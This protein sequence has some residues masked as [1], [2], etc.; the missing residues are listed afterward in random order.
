[1][2][3]LGTSYRNS[4][5]ADC[6][7]A[8]VIGSGM[9]GLA[10]AALLAKHGGKRV[11]VLERNRVAG[12]FTHSFERSGY[13]WNVGVHY[14]G[15]VEDR[16]SLVAEAIDHLTEGRLRWS[17]LPEVYDRLRIGAKEYDMVAGQERFRARMTSYFPSEAANIDRYLAAVKSCFETSTA[18][19]KERA[20]PRAFAWLAGPSL[21]WPFLRWARRTTADVLGR[22]TPHRELAGVLT[23]QWGDYGLPP[24]QSSFGVHSMLVS[25]YMGG[26]SYPVGGTSSLAA[27]VAP[28]IESSGGRILVNAEVSEILLDR[29]QRAVGVRMRDGR[30]LRAG[31]VIS[32]AGARNTFTSLLPADAPGVAAAI[33]ELRSVPP[34]IAHLCLFVGIPQS[35]NNLGLAGANLWI[36]PTPDHDA[37]MAR[38]ARD[39]TAPFPLLFIS[40]PSANDPDFQRRHPGRATLEVVCL[41]PYRWFARWEQPGGALPDH[42]LE[43][44]TARLKERLQA[45]LEEHVPEVRGKLDITEMIT[46]LSTRRFMGCPYGESYGVSAVPERFSIRCLAPRTAIRNL[47]LTGQDACLIGVAGTVMSGVLT[48]SLALGRNLVSV[49]AGKR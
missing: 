9:G 15:Q 11:L 23:G 18:Y 34:S 10:T 49:V 24:G 36:H 33:A 48:A 29:A 38:F 2:A 16:N 28:V 1:L 8:I 25:H 45:S 30:E 31:F 41:V 14:V 42:E 7:D 5:I 37:N 26:A 32:D 22:I 17:P 27:A 40:S 19:F 20:L 43:E 44:F 39:H 6:W 12:G 21:R 46:P 3:T 4:L 13:E 47:Y 35:A